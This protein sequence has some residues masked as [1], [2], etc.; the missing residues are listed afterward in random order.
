[1]IRV[2]AKIIFDFFNIPSVSVIRC[3]QWPFLVNLFKLEDDYIVLD[4]GCGNRSL[5]TE[6]ATRS[7]TRCQINAFDLSFS[8]LS[9][10]KQQSKPFVDF[11]NG[12]VNSLPY[13]TGGVDAILLSS[14][15]QMV[16]DPNMVL[17]ECNRVLKMG[18]MITLSIPTEYIYIKRIF[19][20]KKLL[21]VRL[22]MRLMRM[23][24]N[25]EQYLDSLNHMHGVRGKGYFS[26][27]EIENLLKN[28]D[29]D[30]VEKSISPGLLGTLL[31]EVSVMLSYRFNSSF[32]KVAMFLFFPLTLLDRLF[33]TTGSIRGC[34]L[35]I[36]CIKV[37]FTSYAQSR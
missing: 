4:I 12:D 19:E 18:G 36:K 37:G 13:K 16:P 2:F 6:I 10:A 11:I 26:L 3:M 29:F 7:N 35:I 27:D 23:P 21:F 32:P 30:L 33:P 9:D 31:W 24:S 8:A 28:G 17:S 20:Q 14:V 25:Y 22:I 34:E 1:M 15:L 5:A